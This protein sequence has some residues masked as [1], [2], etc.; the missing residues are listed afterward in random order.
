MLKQKKTFWELTWKLELFTS[1]IPIPSFVY[2]IAFLGGVEKQHTSTVFLT[3]LLCGGYTVVW[4]ILVRYFR[5]KK[6]FRDIDSFRQGLLDSDAAG[7]LKLQILRYPF[8]ESRTIV[9]RW[10]AGHISGFILFRLIAGFLPF[11]TFMVETYS[12]IF[13]LPISYMVY[14][15]VTENTMRNILLNEELIQISL[16]ETVK[17]PYLGYFRR[18]LFSIASVALIPISIFGYFLYASMTKDFQFENPILHISALSMLSVFSMFVV[19]YAVANSLKTGLF[20]TNAALEQLGKGNLFV[21]ASYA[22]SDEFGLQGSLLKEVIMNLRNMYDE[23]MSLNANLEKKVQQRTK[24]LSMTLEQ[25]TEL[26]KQQDGDYF[27]TSLLLSPLSG[28]KGISESVKAEI[29]VSQKKKFDFKKWKSEIG[30]DFCRTEQIQMNGKVYTIAV[31]ADAMGKSMQG[32]GGAIVLGAVFDTIIKRSHG[33]EISPEKWL[34]DCF[35]E[36]HSVFISF[37]GSMLVSAVICIIE[38]DTGLMCYINAEHPFVILHRDERSEFIDTECIY[39][40][41]GTE[42]TKEMVFVRTHQF[43]MNDR[44]LLGSDG[45]DDLV[46]PDTGEMNSDPELFL[47]ICQ[48]SNCDVYSIAEFIKNNYEMTDDFSLLSLEYRKQT[49]ADIWKKEDIQDDACFYENPLLLLRQYEEGVIQ[50]PYSLR[51][52]IVP[53]IQKKNFSGAEKAASIFTGL[54]PSDTEALFLLSYIYRK[55]G[56]FLKAAEVGERIRCREPVHIRN[57]WNLGECYFET[58][59]QEKLKKLINILSVLELTVPV[60]YYKKWNRFLE[61][62]L[63]TVYED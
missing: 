39:R 21:E 55:K 11:K 51:K 22:S 15:T 41:L 62:G 37:E 24:E 60:K 43:H 23:V 45:R 59:A 8:A 49:A 20:S 48:E 34:K 32:A 7:R 46:F 58:G 44:I 25:V 38:E 56:N 10:V 19:S 50:N 12:L 6:I 29:I 61:T 42:L 5:L 33:L 28:K 30:G 52:I 18:I 63:E 57:L 26:K 47:K 35:T 17:P 2:F 16:P 14:L 40:K 27:L 3:G 54:I 53:L 13:V 1:L 4:G 36:L 9:E 31:N